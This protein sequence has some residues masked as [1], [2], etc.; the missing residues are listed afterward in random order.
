LRVAGIIPTRDNLS[1]ALF[2]VNTGLREKEVCVLKWDYE[3]KVPELTGKVVRPHGFE[4]HPGSK[5]Q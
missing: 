1:H 4:P 3:V 5:S 2:K